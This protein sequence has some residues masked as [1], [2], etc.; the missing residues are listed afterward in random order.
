MK[1]KITIESLLNS[2]DFLKNDDI[3]SYEFS[4]R[5]MPRDWNF[6]MMM[7]VFKV[8]N[9]IYFFKVDFDILDSLSDTLGYEYNFS[10]E[11]IEFLRKFRFSGDVCCI[12]EGE[13]IFPG[14]PIMT[15]TGKISEIELIKNMV[16][17]ELSKNIGTLSHCIRCFLASNNVPIIN[18]SNNLLTS[19]LSHI[20]GFDGTTNIL[21]HVKD[22]VPLVAN[23][24]SISCV[25]R[26]EYY[27]NKGIRILDFNDIN[28]TLKSISKTDNNS[29][30]I[31]DKNLDV[32]LERIKKSKINVGSIL[33][34]CKDNTLKLHK[35]S[36]L[37]QTWSANIFTEVELTHVNVES[38][39]VYNQTQDKYLMV[40][41]SGESTLPGVK[42]VY[43]DQRNKQWN[44]LISLKSL[45][46]EE[47]DPLIEIFI[48]NG[49]I[50]QEEI[51]IKAKRSVCNGSLISV[52]N[53]LLCLDKKI[54]KPLKIHRSIL[55]KYYKTYGELNG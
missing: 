37:L 53:K 32:N 8:I 18:T 16:T 22:K 5:N 43:I 33:V 4:I 21:S 26:T 13:I 46:Q 48:K 52:P 45:A 2:F 11:F 44:H 29:I 7:G 23:I 25:L 24:D 54:N 39:P 35:A 55:D 28:N 40:P 19:E 10:D 30:K 14:D 6:M 49:E 1:N 51:D 34:S 20:S 36:M 17:F 27:K 50:V 38:Y 12:P 15:I 31:R 41:T 3:V 47:L 9:N 42:Q